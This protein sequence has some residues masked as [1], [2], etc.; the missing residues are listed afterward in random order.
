MDFEL[1]VMVFINDHGA[2]NPDCRKTHLLRFSNF[3]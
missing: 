3:T 1:V 2:G